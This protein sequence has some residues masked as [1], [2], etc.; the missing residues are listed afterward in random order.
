MSHESRLEHVERCYDETCERARYGA[1]EREL[2]GAELHVG[3]TDALIL[4]RNPYLNKLEQLVEGEL[5]GAEGYLAHHEAKVARVETSDTL[6]LPYFSHRSP[7]RATVLAY[8][9]VLL[10]NLTRV[11][12]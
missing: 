12:D 3:F 4:G 9:Q 1:V 2:D 6:M 10:D 5:D 8:L 7:H 11:P